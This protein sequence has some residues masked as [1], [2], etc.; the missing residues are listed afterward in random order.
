MVREGRQ[1][2][3]SVSLQ[4]PP[5]RHVYA[6]VVDGDRGVADPHAPLAPDDGY[7][8]PNSVVLVG[9]PST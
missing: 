4:L 3:W 1:S 7:G 6:F 5:G 8:A 2:L 9:G